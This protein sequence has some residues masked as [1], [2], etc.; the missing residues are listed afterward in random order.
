MQISEVIHKK[1]WK[2]CA[3]HVHISQLIQSLEVPKGQVA[4]EPELYECHQ[5]RVQNSNGASKVT[6][7]AAGTVHSASMGNFLETKNDILQQQCHYPDIS[8]APPPTPGVYG[9]QKQVSLITDTFDNGA[10]PCSLFLM[11]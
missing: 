1:S 4:K 3:A 11:L 8:Q 7:S 5:I 6:I 9:P 10:S 2:R